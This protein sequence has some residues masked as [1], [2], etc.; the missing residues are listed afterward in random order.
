MTAK[1][2]NTILFLILAG[3]ILGAVLGYYVPDVMLSISVIGTFFISALQLIVM[4]LI[5]ATIITSVASLGEVR[6]LS[7]PLITTL[8]YFVGTTALAVG[9]GLFMAIYLLPG[10]GVSTIG[11]TLPTEVTGLKS[12]GFSD[13]LL[14]FIPT[15]LPQAVIE[16][17]YLAIIVSSLFF[18]GVLAT[19]RQ[20]GRAVVDF[21]RGVSEVILKLVCLILY[22]APIGLFSVVGTIVAKNSG[23]L[24]ELS[25][26]L[27]Y[28]L[29]TLGAGLLI[30]SVIV[31]P[32]LLRF[33]GRRSPLG[34]FGN[35][36]P[37]LSTAL[38]TGSSVAAL[39]ITYTG[40]VDKNKI[41]SRAGALTLPLGMT[42]NL[43]GTAMHLAI[44]ALFVAQAFGVNLSTGQM[45]SIAVVSILVSFGA[46]AIPHAGIL[47][48]LFVLRAAGFP[49]EAY[50][51][52]GLVIVVDWLLDRFCAVVNVW[53][54]SVGAAVVA[55]ALKPKAARLK[56]TARTQPRRAAPITEGTTPA[57]TDSR[58]RDGELTRTTQRPRP[59]RGTPPGARGQRERTKTTRASASTGRTRPGRQTK[60]ATHDR[61]SH[62][63]PERK[64]EPGRADSLKPM[65]AR[66][67]KETSLATA[68]ETKQTAPGEDRSGNT[69]PSRKTVEREIPPI[70]TPSPEY[71]RRKTR[72]G[73]IVKNGQPPTEQG[74]PDTSKGEEEFPLENI[75]FGRHKKKRTR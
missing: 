68:S 37:A 22:V 20:R 10:W 13:V 4:P 42:M 56:R 61:S 6:K 64:R 26:S 29:L 60:P 7:R 57:R 48:L 52:I 24:G 41:D 65:T 2:T 69:T 70:E 43:N 62:H 14:A 16:G 55:V 46:A 12:M 8:V 18:G 58:R 38:A 50:A 21:F 74:E 63:R 47:L 67:R 53:G 27:S 34:Y 31:L 51:G 49:P 71:G 36:I 72:Q 33:V 25:G 1:A 3:I 40:V 5:V 15:S 39:P 44:A 66:T 28:Y 75:S 30:H 32:L 45:I 19:L 11:A 9:I 59:D 35:M 17:Q 23:S 54:D 73:R